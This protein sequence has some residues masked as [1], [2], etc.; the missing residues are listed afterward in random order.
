MLAA[1]AFAD[2]ET[3]SYGV[4][5]F[6]GTNECGSSGQT[7][8]VHTDTSQAFDDAFDAL[9]SAGLWDSS[10]MRDNQLARGS[11]W[12]DPGKQPATGDDLRSN[13]GIDEADVIYI[14][15]HGG[16]SINGTP[17]TWL[18]MGNASY[19]CSAHTNGDMFFDEDLDIAVIKACQSGNYEV[20]QAGGYRQQF[21][22]SSSQFRMWNAFHGN[23][24]CGNHVTRYVDRYASN[25]TYNGVGENW[26]D[27]AYDRDLGSNNDDCPT[28]IVL[29]SS[30]SNRDSMFEWGGWRDRKNTGSRTGSSIYYIGGC[31]PSSGITLPN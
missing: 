23:S 6:G 1:T 15:T 9:Q 31:D 22:N 4:A 17:R 30:S 2:H 26:I 20:W 12:E 11:Y 14:H 7:H 5:N 16:H 27:E 13:Y 19:D 18:K 8:P 3:H 21:S 28:S 24:S 25:S 29:G 10:L